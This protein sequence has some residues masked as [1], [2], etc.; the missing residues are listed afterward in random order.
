MQTLSRLAAVALVAVAVALP[1]RA[2]VAP[3]TVAPGTVLDGIAAVVGDEIVLQSE[4]TALAQQASQGQPVTNELWS[5]ALDELVRQRVLVIHA[6]RDTT[7]IIAEEQVNQQLDQQVGQ[8]A[9]QAGG[10]AAL[11]AY[12]RKTTE[13]IKE[14]F[15]EDVRK[16]L[17]AERL[18]GVRMRDVS[19]T[20]GEV[21]NW[22]DQIPVEERPEVPEIVRVAHIVKVPA[23][24]PEAKQNARDF[25]G[26]LRDSVLAE[27]ATIEELA[28]R[29]S[30]D[31]GSGSRG[32]LIENIE[33]RLLVPEFAAV[34]GSVELGALSQV[35]ESPFG[36]H[37]MRVTAREAGK[38]TFNH[39]LIAVEM[40]ADAAQIARDELM[41]LRDSVLTHGVAFEGIARR[42]SDDPLSAA[43]GGFVSD[44]RTGERD[45][46][47][48]ALGAQWQGTVDSL[49]VGDLSNPGSVRLLD[50]A[51]TQALHVVLLQKRTP[52]H[53]LSVETDYALL[54]QY[55][56]NDKRREVFEQWLTRL[57]R[58]VYVDIRSA[59]YI[60]PTPES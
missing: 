8:M 57:Q 44:P 24:S 54:S 49:K 51:G 27:Q 5:R 37:F 48:E 6:Q 40:G 7:I 35:F 17:L 56:L 39:I 30:D 43:R 34:A 16:Q 41:M 55:A 58:D 22:L 21:R 31:G 53:E 19:V 50:G 9:A 4:A 26:A 32:G 28:R 3:G 42:H 11:E 45:I 14:T 33:L 47:L 29:H 23:A 38:V 20:P 18:R 10:E 59:R 13:E 60:A 12:Y 2:Q 15:R 52:P 25:A 36:Y 46:R 1:S